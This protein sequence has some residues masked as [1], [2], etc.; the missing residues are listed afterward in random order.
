MSA[1]KDTKGRNLQPGED[2]MK[3][4]RYRYRYTNNQC[5]R[6]TIY[7]W[8]LVPTDKTPKGKHEDLSLR[9]KIIQI[10]KDLDDDIHPG[11]ADI[12]VTKLLLKYL[13]TKAT[14][15]DTTRNNYYRMT[16]DN[17]STHKFG[18][19]IIKNVKK[20][21]VKAF[22]KYLYTERDFAQGTIQLYQNLIFPAFQMAVEDRVIR[23]NP[24]VGCMKDYP[25]GSMA[26]DKIPLTAREQ[27]T[28]LDFVRQSAFYCNNFYL[29]AFILGTGCRIGEALGM[30]W[31][32]IHLEEEYID[33]N[34]Q[35]IYKEKELGGGMRYY[36]G[37]P[38]HD[39]FRKVP[40]QKDLV[41]LLYK[42]K[43]ERYYISQVSS[44]VVDGVSG[45]VFL[46]RNDRVITPGTA[47]RT[48]LGI[49]RA[50]NKQEET[51]AIEE[52]RPP[53]YFPHISTHSLRHTYCTRMAENGCDIKVL[54][55][56]MGHKNIAVTMQVYNHTDFERNKKAVENV[57]SILGNV[58]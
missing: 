41:N 19:L 32:D 4:G 25:Q 1:R 56:L 26:S 3:D 9:E 6:Q 18:K 53:K 40:I 37:P 12:T 21:D 7:A 50:I 35:I 13:D 57:K 54:Q 43:E 11:Y 8:K 51:L 38:K 20:S 48:L 15:K 44:F 29:I 14:L 34:H 33:I 17:I 55:S 23:L 27:N 10:K 42:L 45:F 49:E 5:E 2:Q 30:T 46:N 39:S 16:E 58:I 36:I 28:L 47:N 22:Y 52:K 24:C 31:D